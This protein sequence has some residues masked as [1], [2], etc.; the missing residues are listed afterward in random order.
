M[1][2]VLERPVKSHDYPCAELHKTDVN[3]AIE[4]ETPGC[5]PKTSRSRS[6]ATG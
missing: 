5:G 6:T 1:T 2:A 4:V 3:F